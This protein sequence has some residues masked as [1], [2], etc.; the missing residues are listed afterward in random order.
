MLLPVLLI[1]GGLLA[2]VMFSKPAVAS[3]NAGLLAA[4]A[5]L[6]NLAI[7]TTP[8]DPNNPATYGGPGT[9]S[10][11]APPDWGPTGV[12]VLPVPSGAPVGSQAGITSTGAPLY[13]SGYADLRTKMDIAHD[14]HGNPYLV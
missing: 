11:V 13:H 6:A 14:S 8:Y 7:P 1:G 9:P 10:T 12:G 3:Q 4:D 2:Y 5:S